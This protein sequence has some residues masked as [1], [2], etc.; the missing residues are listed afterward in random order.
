MKTDSPAEY[1]VSPVLG[2]CVPEHY[3]KTLDQFRTLIADSDN[4]IP[5]D[6]RKQLCQIYTETGEGLSSFVPALAESYDLEK[7]EECFASLLYCVFQ[8]TDV[9]GVR[10]AGGITNEVLHEMR[11]M[12][13]KKTQQ[14]SRLREQVSDAFFN[15]LTEMF[16]TLL[17][18]RI[19]QGALPML[20]QE[21]KHDNDY[22]LS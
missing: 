22:D 12:A 3:S 15:I 17:K 20:E 9:S 18:E 13:S 7:V 16:H 19:K 2:I 11:R 8:V 10:K 6:V 4:G 1:D 14:D 21:N 5:P